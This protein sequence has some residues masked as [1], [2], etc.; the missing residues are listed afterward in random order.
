[1]IYLPTLNLGLAGRT[2][3]KGDEILAVDNYP[4]HFAWFDKAE[5]ERQGVKR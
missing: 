4:A 5:K 3:L 1:V 2:Y